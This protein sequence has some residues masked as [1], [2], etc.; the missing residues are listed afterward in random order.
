MHPKLFQQPQRWLSD[1]GHCRVPCLQ[2]KCEMERDGDPLGRDITLE[3]SISGGNTVRR[4]KATSAMPCLSQNGAQLISSAHTTLL[5]LTWD[6]QVPGS[7]EGR[8]PHPVALVPVLV[9]TRVRPCA[10]QGDVQ[11]HKVAHLPTL[12]FQAVLL[13]QILAEDDSGD[14]IRMEHEARTLSPG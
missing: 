5:C 14:P 6:S 4:G 12:G 1:P 13:H 10:A 9:P 3:T 7:A 11:Q 8:A 2:Q